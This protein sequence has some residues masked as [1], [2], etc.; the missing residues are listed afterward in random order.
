LGEDTDMSDD[1]PTQRFETPATPAPAATEE[2]SKNRVPLILGIV[3]GVLLIAV[4]VLLILLLG[5]S[6]SS[7][8]AASTASAS[9]TPTESSSPTPVPIPTVTVTVTPAPS[10]GGGGGAPAKPN[11]N[12]VLITNYSISPTTVD[13]SSSAPA[14]STNLN[15]S[16][17]SVNG[18]EAFFGVETSDAQA[19]GEGWTLPASG[20]Q[21][22]FP[23]GYDPF[24]YVCG[25]AVQH[26]TI[27]VVGNGSK[28]S[29][30]FTV[31]RK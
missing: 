1:T 5:K 27:T 25:D 13:C 30:T 21:H 11:G 12:N 22:D 24:T 15:I 10:G 3:G 28:Q 9:P 31:Q 14:G 7:T 29:L 19:S 6:P 18:S 23:S 8:S 17:K 16:W 2:K 4:I 26:F 20:T